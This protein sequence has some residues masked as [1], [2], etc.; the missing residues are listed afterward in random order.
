MPNGKGLLGHESSSQT[1]LIVPMHWN[2]YLYYL[3]TIDDGAINKGKNGLRYSIVDMR[4]N[5]GKGDVVSGKKNI[6]LMAKAG[7]RLTAVEHKNLNSIWVI[8]QKYGSNEYYSYEITSSGIKTPIISRVGPN[9]MNVP[10]FPTEMHL[11]CLKVDPLGKNIAFTYTGLSSLTLADFNNNTGVISNARTTYMKKFS[12][13]YGVEFSPNGAYLYLSL[14]EEVRQFDVNVP[15]RSFRRNRGILVL[16]KKSITYGAIQQAKNRKLYV[17]SLNFPGLAVTR[18]ERT[19]D[20][21]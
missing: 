6:V 17:S 10:L 20:H 19:G 1:A 14:Y 13:P 18:H 11:G 3:F 7:E 4:L 2:K 8:A 12:L 15:P 16:K 21:L 9:P 5:G